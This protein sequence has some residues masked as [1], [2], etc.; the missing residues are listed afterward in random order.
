MNTVLLIV[1]H[2]VT[3]EL[4]KMWFVER[5][6]VIK[7]LTGNFP[8]SA[9]RCRSA[10]VTGRSPLESRPVAFWDA[11]TLVTLLSGTLSPSF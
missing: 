9:P 3:D 8:P 7:N 5:D 11:L 2:V 10:S 1:V 6:D 4:T